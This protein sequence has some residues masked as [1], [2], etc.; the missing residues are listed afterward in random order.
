MIRNREEF[1]KALWEDYRNFSEENREES[2]IYNYFKRKKDMK[3]QQIARDKN[4][5]NEYQ[6]KMK[7]DKYIQLKS[8]Y[9]AYLDEVLTEE[10]YMDIFREVTCTKK[11]NSSERTLPKKYEDLSGKE[12][13]SMVER[14]YEKRFLN[15]CIS[16]FFQNAGY[17]VNK[18]NEVE[19]HKKLPDKHRKEKDGY[20]DE[21]SML[22]AYYQ[23]CGR[24][25]EM[26]EVITNTLPV[27]DE[28]YR[29]KCE[30]L[31]RILQKEKRK[32]VF[33]PLY[34]DTSTGA[35]IYIIGKNKYE[36]YTEKSNV[37]GS[38][39]KQKE[40]GTT[41]FVC[42]IYFSAIL[43]RISEFDEMDISM[44]VESFDTLEEAFERFQA[45]IS[46]QEF[47]ENYP[48]ENED[49][50]PEG[51]DSNF[52]LFFVEKRFGF[53]KEKEEAM[54]KKIKEE[55]SKKEQKRYE[56]AL[57]IEKKKRE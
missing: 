39:D 50:L 57:L 22:Y 43:D 44:M 29:N 51:A 40:D 36:E 20:T 48:S 33:V 32:E 42:V 47:Y 3:A 5:L 1:I 34:V 14:K 38:R 26:K 21:L 2:F 49:I 56:Q 27:L 23:Y 8:A 12:E 19:E 13:I 10:E 52:D 37:Y 17:R 24:A 46:R 11:K 4:S 9:L 18:K 41:C 28:E 6:L 35:G 45:G 16:D 54:R 25:E 55:Q 53:A 31:L 30:K 15:G 7:R